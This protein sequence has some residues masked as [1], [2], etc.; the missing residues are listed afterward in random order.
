MA[1]ALSLAGLGPDATTVELWADPGV[2]RNIHEI[3]CEADSARFEMRIENVPTA[4]NPRTGR[5]TPLSVL[6]C[7]EG[8]VSPLKV[9]T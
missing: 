6:A 4:E 9:G 3:V 5:I 8:L 1:A 2:D 7:L